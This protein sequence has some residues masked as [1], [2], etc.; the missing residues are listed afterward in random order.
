VSP[1]R[2]GTEQGDLSSA[3]DHVTIGQNKNEPPI[4]GIT[5]IV[6]ADDQFLVLDQKSNEVKV[7]GETGEYEYAF[8]R[9][10]EGPGEFTVPRDMTQDDRGR[11]WVADADRS[12][13][14]FSKQNGRYRSLRT[15]S[16]DKNPQG[17]CAIDGSLYVYGFSP[18]DQ[19]Q[20]PITQ[21]SFEGEK[22]RDFGSAY[23]SDNPLVSSQLSRISSMACSDEGKM[24]I[25]YRYLPVTFV[26]SISSSDNDLLFFY[27]NQKS[28]SIRTE[29]GGG[30]VVFSEPEPGSHLGGSISFR[31]GDVLI[32]KRYISDQYDDPYDSF[33]V[34][35]KKKEVDVYGRYEGEIIFLG[36]SG[37]VHKHDTFVRIHDE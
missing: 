12:I 32:N 23:K 33:L 34:S 13:S 22:G 25:Q 20:Q 28:I 1:E 30:E 10:G 8:G 19:G 36:K 21:Y 2:N 16:V 27:E 35:V 14:V 4:A 26:E 15:F 17:L 5:E 18:S 6:K 11:I 7:Y 3:G 31:D 9:P 29:K 24:I 37:I